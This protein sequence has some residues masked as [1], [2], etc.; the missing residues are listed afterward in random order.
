M[1]QQSPQGKAVTGGAIATDHPKS[2]V[3]QKGLVAEGLPAMNVAEMELHK[4]DGNGQQGVAQGDRG[5]RVRARIDQQAI[6][7]APGGLDAIHQGPF[8]IALEASQGGA[9]CLGFLSQRHLN[10]FQGS[11]AVEAGFSEAKEIEVGP[12]E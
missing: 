7:L 8:M 1:G 3:S 2:F 11:A 12:V 5:V 9:E 10:L 4:R 6:H